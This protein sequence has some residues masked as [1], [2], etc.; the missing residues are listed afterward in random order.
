MFLVDKGKDER[1]RLLKEMHILAD[2][3]QSKE[4][5]LQSANAK[6]FTVVH[7]GKHERYRLLNKMHILA[8]ALQSKEADL[9]SANA[10]LLA[11]EA[12]LDALHKVVCEVHSRLH[13]HLAIITAAGLWP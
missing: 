13:L 2:A 1:D 9:Q 4:A 3:L 8:D 7:Q 12:Q 10:K 5:D 6:L 11:A